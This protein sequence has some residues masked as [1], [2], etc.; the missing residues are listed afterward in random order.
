MSKRTTVRKEIP[1][2]GANASIARDTEGGFKPIFGEKGT[3]MPVIGTKHRYC[4][5]LRHFDSVLVER[6]G[7]QCRFRELYWFMGKVIHVPSE[8][9]GKWP[10][11]LLRGSGF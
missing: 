8:A 4:Q 2:F 5:L 1:P 6:V 10:G 3:F 9:M 7:E 11:K